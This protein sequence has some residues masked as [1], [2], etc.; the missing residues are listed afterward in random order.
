MRYRT[1]LAALVAL[2][3]GT[4]P[5][6]AASAAGREPGAIPRPAGAAAPGG[7]NSGAVAGTARVTLVTGDVVRLTTYDDRAP[8]A[9]AKR[10]VLAGHIR[11]IWLDGQV[12]ASLDQS[13]P[14]I[15]APEAWA[16]GYDGKGVTVAVL[17]TG[18]DT[19]HPDLADRVVDSQN[20]SPAP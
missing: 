19:T 14:Q 7:T 13:V 4:A 17:D 11:K 15:G 8:A 16:A 18:I 10:P 9:V 12:K 3:L 20:F 5:A 6:A 2:A 1:G